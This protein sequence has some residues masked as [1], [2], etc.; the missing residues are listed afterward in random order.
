MHN[1]KHWLITLI[2]SGLASVLGPAVAA[3]DNFVVPSWG[4][5]AWNYGPGTDPAMDT[6]QAL[7][8][9]FRH[10]KGRG[11]T[12]IYLRTD[13]IQLDP[14][15]I[16]RNPPKK[17]DPRYDVIWNSIDEIS[18]RFDVHEYGVKLSKPT[19]FEFWAWHPHLYSDG[20]PEDA[21]SPGPG[22]IWPWSYVDAYTYNHQEIVTVDRKGNKYWMVRE[23][24]YPGARAS[25]VAEFVHLARKYHLKN[26]VACMRS[27]SSQVQAPPDKADRYGFSALVVADMKRLYGVDILTDPRF[28]ADDPKFDPLDPMVGKW[29]DLRGSYVTQF[30]RELRKAL[31]EVDPGI[32]LAVTLSGDHVGPP[33][34][35]WR[36]DWRRWVDEG[37][38]DEIISPVFFE[39]TLDLQSEKKGYLTDVK[40]GKGVIP[41]LVLKQYI[42]QSG[43]PEIKLIAGGGMPYEFTAPPEG[44]DGW[45]TDVWYSAYHLAWYQRW[46]QWKK[47][48][49]EL[50]YIRFFEQNFDDLPVG[51]N[52][53]SG[54]WGDARYIPS[55][56]ACPGSWQTLGDGKDARPAAQ[57]QIR[58]GNQGRA[59]RLTRAAEGRGRLSGWHAS[60]PDRSNFTACLDNSITCGKAAFEF[61]LYRAD[62]DSSVSAYLQNGV[63]A[64]FQQDVPGE[65]DVGLRIARTT[66]RLL[67][68]DGTNWVQT[69]YSLEP[70]QWQKFT[71]DLD[72]DALTYGAKAG[73]DGSIPL[74]KDVRVGAAK[75]RFIE[76]AGVNVPVPVKAYRT[77]SQVLF[78][79]EGA[80]ANV[81]YLDDVSVKWTPTLYYQ[82]PGRQVCFAD[83]FE[84]HPVGGGINNEAA[85]K[86]GKWQAEPDDYFVDNNTSY[87]EGVK[88]LHARRGAVLKGIAGH[89]LNLDGKGVLTV[90]LDLFVR[91]DSSF[92]YIVPDPTTKS[93]HRTGVGL[94]E[95]GVGKTVVGAYAG[96]GTWNYWDADHYQDSGVKIAY[97]VWNHVQMALD[98]A[99]GTYQVVVQ[100][101]GEMPTLV[102][103]RARAGGKAAIGRE[104]EFVIRPSATPG[105]SSLYDNVLVAHD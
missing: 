2:L 16:R 70:G 105:H 73:A 66:G 53:H 12:G 30:Y 56:R 41:Y 67:F 54:G 76:Q 22:R 29:H 61:W 40:N 27:E 14:G 10:W 24:A 13:L 32:R 34:G 80:D 7:E 33:L 18:A 97:D 91:S 50:G 26:F 81:I 3:V 46:E 36:L 69:G 63:P 71:I 95:K 25:K 94:E 4:D 58:H 1:F 43:H 72:I 21:G 64:Y 44:A 39:A 45:R 99:S 31:K 60:S 48:L 75:P 8:S 15:M 51:N 20:A 98:E 93:K 83:D 52:G 28:D 82:Q 77:F 59:I 84:S 68:A 42:R 85:P 35:N 6:P 87:G 57:E 102:T 65:T 17:R 9:M 103:S 47:D 88:S 86:G 79:P 96:D 38:I 5:I 11:F 49:K 100:P 104:A 92:P 101:V 55:L 19:G 74:C 37:L 62:K 89:R 78:E 23:Y 90:D